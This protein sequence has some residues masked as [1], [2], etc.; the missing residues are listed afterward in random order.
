MRAELERPIFDGAFWSSILHSRTFW[1][2]QDHGA[3]FGTFAIA[4]LLFAS[5]LLL[6]RLSARRRGISELHGD[7]SGSTTLMDFVLV[8]PIFVFFMF[9]VFQFAILAKNHLFT[10]YAAY[11]AARSARVYFC[12]S[13]PITPRSALGFDVE[14]CDDDAAAGKADLAARLALIPAAPYGQLK[15]V[16]A[17]QPPED[18][19]KTIADASGLSKNWRAMRNQARYMFD[20]QNVTV[21]VDR[22]PMAP[23]A[24]ANRLPHVPVVATVEARFLLLE[25]AGW[26]FARGQRKDGRYYTISKAEVSLL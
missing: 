15:C 11:S 16:G 18:A 19:L 1:I 13:F 26:I 21:T 14:A 25:Y 20:P 6:P 4:S 23:Y 24:A 7:I 9:V 17:C 8:T 5:M 22:A 12:P 10:H 2:P 3:L